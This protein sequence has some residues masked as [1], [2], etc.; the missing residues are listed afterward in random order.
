[1]QLLLLSLLII[2]AFHRKLIAPKFIWMTN[3]WYNTRWWSSF[4][5]PCTSEQIE[6]ALEGS[7]GVIPDGYVPREGN[8]STSFGMVY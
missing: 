4:T 6:V 7:I 2:Q 1:M 5:S 3:L 8:L